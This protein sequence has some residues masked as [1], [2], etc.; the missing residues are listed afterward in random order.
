MTSVYQ[1]ATFHPEP[2][3]RDE[4][5]RGKSSCRPSHGLQ[6]HVATSGAA[7]GCQGMERC[8]AKLKDVE[9]GF[10]RIFR[11]IDEMFSPSISLQDSSAVASTKSEQ[12]WVFVTMSDFF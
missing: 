4:L 8:L 12:P 2:P 1:W 10:R 5:A 11:M 7:M 6:Q 9:D 3:G